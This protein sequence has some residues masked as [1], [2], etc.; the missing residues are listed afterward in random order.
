M[1][2][3]LIV[4]YQNVVQALWHFETFAI[5][6]IHTHSHHVVATR[7]FSELLSIR[8]TREGKRDALLIWIKRGVT[9]NS[10]TRSKLIK[11]IFCLFLSFSSFILFYLTHL[12]SGGKI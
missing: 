12:K 7:K 2:L 1:K 10:K 5:T 11:T 3:I 6:Y 8:E 4:K 9:Y